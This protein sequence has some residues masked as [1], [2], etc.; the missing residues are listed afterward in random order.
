MDAWN[1][2]MNGLVTIVRLRGGVEK[3]GMNGNLEYGIERYAILSPFTIPHSS[4]SDNDHSNVIAASLLIDYKIPE[5][6]L[7]DKN[8]DRMDLSTARVSRFAEGLPTRYGRTF[9]RLVCK[10]G[11]SQ[12]LVDV[13]T[14][15]ADLSAVFDLPN[16][17]HWT[18]GDQLELGRCFNNLL[19]L[20]HKL[21]NEFQKSTAP[22]FKVQRM[23]ECT[24]H[25]ALLFLIGLRETP[26]GGTPYQIMLKKSRSL[27]AGTDLENVWGGGER[28]GLLL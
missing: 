1:H 6:M 27:L 19:F 28:G 14:G 5:I 9:Q 2:H 11:L 22:N 16:Q 21:I 7:A 24:R 17:K 15:A 20:V 4:P 3:L 26:L 18:E 23:R 13:C 8:R 25:A 12:G 10:D